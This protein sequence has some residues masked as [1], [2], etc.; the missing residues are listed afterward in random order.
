MVW[1]YGIFYG[2][3]Q[4]ALIIGLI[5]ESAK[6]NAMTAPFVAAMTAWTTVGLVA[7]GVLLY[8]WLCLKGRCEQ[9]A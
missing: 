2:A 4:V 1:C 3:V 9:G 6:F 8:R 5:V 7:L